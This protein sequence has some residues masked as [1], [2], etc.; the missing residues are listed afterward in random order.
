MI[1]A[2]PCYSFKTTT[3]TIN[4]NLKIVVVEITLYYD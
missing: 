3:A 4:K 1:V 2:K